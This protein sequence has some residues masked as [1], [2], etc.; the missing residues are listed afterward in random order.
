MNVKTTVLKRCVRLVADS[1]Q[2]TDVE[3]KEAALACAN[4]RRAAMNAQG[5]MSVINASVRGPGHLIPPG[6]IARNVTSLRQYLED[7]MEAL[8]RLPGGEREGD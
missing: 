1:S 3:K 8:G 7:L 4:V 5:E 2:L 6:A